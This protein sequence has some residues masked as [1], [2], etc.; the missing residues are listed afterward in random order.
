MEVV[1]DLDED[2]FGAFT[3]GASHHHAGVAEI[4]V[5]KHCRPGF[6]LAR[7]T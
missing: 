6:E 3:F 4:A 7:I 1:L 5:P 2:W